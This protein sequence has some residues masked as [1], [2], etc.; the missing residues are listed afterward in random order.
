M[1]PAAERAD[2]HELVAAALDRPEAFSAIIE[3]YTAPL[4]RYL[5]RLGCKDPDDQADVLQNTFIKTYVNLNDFDTK[6]KFSSWI[7]RIAH[8]ETVSFLRKK[9]HREVLLSEEEELLMRERIADSTDV[10][11]EVEAAFD[12]ERLNKA[13]NALD[14]KYREVLILKFLEEKSYE[15]ISDILRTPPGTV[16]T[17][18]HRAKKKLETILEQQAQQTPST[19]QSTHHA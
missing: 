16:A 17:L 3:K 12:R 1:E 6:L 13:I 4:G 8:N 11:H 18:I 15:E 14:P 2:D 5:R 10:E 19:T 7:Y 9:K